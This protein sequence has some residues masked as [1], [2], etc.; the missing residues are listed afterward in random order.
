MKLGDMVT[1]KT[2]L[3]DADFWIV[4]RGSENVVGKPVKVYDPE[5]I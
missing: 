5:Y 2:G 4:R 3:S 1:V